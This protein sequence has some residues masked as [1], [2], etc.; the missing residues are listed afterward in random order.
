MESDADRRGVPCDVTPGP[1]PASPSATGTMQGC[2]HGAR[3][4]ARRRRKITMEIRC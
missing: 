1:L 4:R 3:T 2:V